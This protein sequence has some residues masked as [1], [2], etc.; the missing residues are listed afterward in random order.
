MPLSSSDET[1]KIPTAIIEINMYK[2]KI[3]DRPRGFMINQLTKLILKINNSRVKTLQRIH[4][5]PSKTK[6][7]WIYFFDVER[8]TS[9]RSTSGQ[10]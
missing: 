9:G 2:I 4:V 5:A 10:T 6:S 1:D 7:Q 8:S 3:V